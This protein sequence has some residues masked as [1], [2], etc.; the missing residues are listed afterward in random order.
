MK[1]RWRKK[2]M[3]LDAIQI[4]LRRMYTSNQMEVDDTFDDLCKE[5]QTTKTQMKQQELD[6]DM[7]AQ[8]ADLRNCVKTMQGDLRCVL[9]GC[10]T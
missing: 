5:L 6:T 1:S 2:A 4:G 10:N 9:F 7:E 8:I 3:A